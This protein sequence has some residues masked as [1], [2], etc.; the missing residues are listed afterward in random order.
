MK[1]KIDM[2]YYLKFYL[3][4]LFITHCRIKSNWCKNQLV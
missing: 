1:K 3:N 2:N 4:I